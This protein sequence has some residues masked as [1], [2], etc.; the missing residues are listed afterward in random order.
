MV[1]AAVVV[2]V[3]LLVRLEEALA[4][5]AGFIAAVIA[6]VAQHLSGFTTEAGPGDL[7]RLTGYMP[8]RLRF[9]WHEARV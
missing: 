4:T 7:I 9:Q 1:V 6:A 2:L 5:K 8:K 3:L